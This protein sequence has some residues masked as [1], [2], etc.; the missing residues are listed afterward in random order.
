MLCTR[1]H[2][3][4]S[5][6]LASE[7]RCVTNMRRS[8]RHIFN[9]LAFFMIFSRWWKVV[10][11]CGRSPCAKIE[12]CM[13][14]TGTCAGGRSADAIDR[15]GT[16]HPTRPNATLAGQINKRLDGA[17]LISG[18]NTDRFLYLFGVLIQTVSG[19]L[20][21]WPPHYLGRVQLWRVRNTVV[22]PDLLVHLHQELFV[23]FGLVD[24]R[25]VQKYYELSYFLYT[26]I[27][28][29]IKPAVLAFS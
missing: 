27:R 8:I 16:L 15:V 19:C 28:K 23:R 6:K 26:Y 14:C 11:Q 25:V 29:S 12:Y 24:H 5:I 20:T 2:T 3:S 21:K 1:S 22:H 10:M 7:T 13:R 17:N 4:F 9:T 18:H